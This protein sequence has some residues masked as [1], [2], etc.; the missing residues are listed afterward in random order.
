[1]TPEQ[2]RHARALLAQ[3]DNS[4]ASIAKLLGVSRTTI[5]KY[6]PRTRRRTGLSDRRAGPGTAHSSRLT[7]A[8][9]ALSRGAVR[10]FCLR[11]AT[12]VRYSWAP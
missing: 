3:P 1:M 5:D 12:E 7:R 6:V 11:V 4:V 9:T 10:R 8:R 2:I